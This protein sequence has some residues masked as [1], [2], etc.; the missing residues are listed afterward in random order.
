MN[1]RRL[2]LA[3]AVLVGLSSCEKTQAPVPVDGV[4][5]PV[6][7]DAAVEATTVMPENSPEAV[8]G[9]FPAG[10]LV[11]FEL[12]AV[13]VNDVALSKTPTR[14]E[15]RASVAMHGWLADE[16]TMAWP[17]DAALYIQREG[18]QVAVWSVGLTEPKPRGDVA[19]KF[20][21]ETMRNTGFEV[22]KN[23]A[24]LPA[25]DYRLVLGFQKDGKQ[26]LCDRNRL[27]HLP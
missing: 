27:V 13:R 5:D 20:N 26:Y 10:E 24:G 1:S 6:N 14:I 7:V 8:S 11:E 15:D 21:A 22:T 12:C 17:A 3:M 23:L 2:V 9:Q 16:E 25:G 18:E 19:R 4:V